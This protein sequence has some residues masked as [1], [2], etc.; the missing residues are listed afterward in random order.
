MGVVRRST[1]T[2]YKKKWGAVHTGTRICAT[3]KYIQ[4]SK[5]STHRKICSDK[6]RKEEKN[7]K[8][9]HSTVH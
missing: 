4:S 2:K 6:L 1:Y 8:Y 9:V 5:S 7:T 3:S